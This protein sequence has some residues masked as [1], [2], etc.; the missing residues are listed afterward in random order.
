MQEWQEKIEQQVGQLQEEV[1][2]LKEQRT[3]EMKAINVNVGSA[4]VLNRLD[5]LKQE[6]DGRSETWLNTL[7]QNYDEHK[8]VISDIQTVQRGHS[9]FFEEHG[10]RLAATATKDDIARLEGLIRQLLPKQE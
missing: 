3:E 5:D 2:Q 9:K 7:Q 6:L 8:Q 10:K 4:D 1:R